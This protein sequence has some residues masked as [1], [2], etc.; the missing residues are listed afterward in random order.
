M[1]TYTKWKTPQSRY[2]WFV[3]DTVEMHLLKR[4]NVLIHQP[5]NY[6]L[7]FFFFSF[8]PYVQ[9][10]L[11]RKQEAYKG[12]VEMLKCWFIE[13]MLKQLASRRRINNTTS[14]KTYCHPLLTTL[15]R[16]F[17]FSVNRSKKG[18]RYR[19]D[20]M[21]ILINGCLF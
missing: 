19:R 20:A 8:L 17:L 1:Y 15:V 3:N 11:L 2:N 9:K 10:Y 16:L 4:L 13:H 12:N 21:A 5:K 18:I 7:P 14:K 6:F